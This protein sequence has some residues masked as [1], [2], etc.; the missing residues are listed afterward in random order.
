MAILKND[1]TKNIHSSKCSLLKLSKFSKNLYM[2]TCDVA[3][4]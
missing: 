3:I 4:I 2:N 1:D